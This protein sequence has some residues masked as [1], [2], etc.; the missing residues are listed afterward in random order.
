MKIL[1]IIGSGE[2][3]QQI[4][5]HAISDKHFEDVVFFDDFTDEKTRNGYLIFGKTKDIKKA[6]LEGKFDA[7][8]IGIGYKYMGV[9]KELFHRFKKDKIPFA[10]IIHTTSFIDITANISEGT[11]IYPMCTIDKGVAIGENVL[12]NNNVS[13]SHDSKIG[14]HSFI[15]PSCSIAGFVSVGEQ[16][17]IGINT[18]IIDSIELT[19]GVQTGGGAVIVKNINKKGLYIGNPARFIR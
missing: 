16:S 12:L 8:M 2:L 7:L 19:Q 18:T 6:F 5:H 11:I 9:R 4:A 1:G 17:N 15:S 14:A 3:G 10:K 13:I